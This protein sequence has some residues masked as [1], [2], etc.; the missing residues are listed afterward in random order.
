MIR[1]ARISSFEEA[2]AVGARGILSAPVGAPTTSTV[3]SAP[4]AA[5]VCPSGSDT[6]TRGTMLGGSYVGLQ[7]KLAASLLVLMGLGVVEKGM[8]W[9]R[10]EG[11]GE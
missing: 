1:P 10:R 8:F 7:W 2:A 9:K 5:P 6:S 3:S 11:W 4:V